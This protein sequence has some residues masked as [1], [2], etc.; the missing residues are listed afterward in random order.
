M[1][2]DSAEYLY[3]LNMRE[4][5]R[6]RYL[7]RRRSIMILAVGMAAVAS[8]LYFLFF[9]GAPIR[10]I[11]ENKERIMSLQAQGYEIIPDI[12][13]RIE[14][15]NRQLKLLT[16]DSIENRLSI[17]EEAIR[18]GD[19][20]PDEIASIQQMREDLNELKS[21][22]FRDP[23]EMV[24][25]K[26]LQSDYRNLAQGLKETPTIEAM[27]SQISFTNNLLFATWAF[28]GILFTILFG[29][30]PKKPKEHI[31]TKPISTEAP[32]SESEGNK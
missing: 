23:K 10:G 7:A 16:T 26:Q 31:P 14:S 8:V 20:S 28:F 9:L 27:K 19:A 1:N 2:D 25:L 32:P 5:M 11:L 22:M 30:R 13:E 21:Y 24:E 18:V 6:E 12:E 3:H 17:I 15:V 29:T 4:S